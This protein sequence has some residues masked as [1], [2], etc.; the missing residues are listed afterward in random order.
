MEKVELK[1][2]VG[3]KDK[4]VCI[5]LLSCKDVQYRYYLPHD[6]DWNFYFSPVTK[7]M[8][9]MSKYLSGKGDSSA[10]A[11][12]LPATDRYYEIKDIV[13]ERFELDGVVICA[14]CEQKLHFA[15]TDRR[16]P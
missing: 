16:S 10:L 5:Y 3:V 9:Q 13:E 11:Q 7:V 8:E 14:G 1:E 12:L 4:E 15:K 6:S 2:C